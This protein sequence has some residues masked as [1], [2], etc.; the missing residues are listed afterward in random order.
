M[1][2]GTLR[3][4]K[5]WK[6]LA[7]KIARIASTS[8]VKELLPSKAALLDMLCEDIVVGQPLERDGS[9]GKIGH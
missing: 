8:R 2:M 9:E 1:G 5:D 3:T 4:G 7:I 6:E